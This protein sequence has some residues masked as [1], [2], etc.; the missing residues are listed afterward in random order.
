MYRNKKSNKRQARGSVEARRRAI[1]FNLAPRRTR[2]K[3][4][5]LLDIGVDSSTATHMK[6]AVSFTS[7]SFIDIFFG[8]SNLKRS[9]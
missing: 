1:D 6:S 4:E 8:S 3:L 9:R 2:L 5:R 7:E